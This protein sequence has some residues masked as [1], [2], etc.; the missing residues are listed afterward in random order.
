MKKLFVCMLAGALM[1]SAGACS[2]S[3]GKDSGTPASEP[4]YDSKELLDIGMWVGVSD[5]ITEYDDWGNKTG[6]VTTLTDEEFLE[7]YQ[8]IAESG[9]TIAFPG[10]EYMLWGTETYNKKCL[11][12]AHEVGIKQLI[13]IPAL[14]DYLSKAK[15]LVESGVDTEEQAVEK[16][17]NYLKPYVEYEYADAFYGC[18]IGDEPAADKFDQH[19]FAQKI[20]TQAA[21]DLCYYVNLFPVIA[22]GAQLGGATPISYET[23]IAQYLEKV[24]T[25]YLSYDHYPLKKSRDYFLE[26]SFLQNMEMVRKALDEEGKNR[27]MWTFLQ[28]ISFGNNRPL[29]SI[30]DAAFQAYSFL[31]YGGDGIQW[32]CFTCPPPYD[33]AGYFG[34][35]ALLDRDYQK[36]ATFDY[37]KTANGYLQAMM[38][39]Y[40]NFTWK[41]V[42]TSSEDGGEGNFERVQRMESAKT[43]KKVEGTEDVLVGVFEDKDAREGY[44]VVNFTDPGRKLDNEVTLTVESVH[45]AIV[46]LNG[47]KSVRPVKDGK[48]TLSLKSGEG[49]FVIP[50]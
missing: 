7:K 20:F 35:D 40:K 8:W 33:G 10:Y 14:N 9:I 27:K 1:F 30:G 21:P 28:S 2:G 12:A 48:L 22:G 6:K 39:Y 49:C 34:N 32:F 15:T 13:S 26:G 37:V 36:T 29:E 42:M 31:A 46:V 25:P 5:K 23:Y 11:K 17:K 50:Y 38:P 24:K 16:V 19:G 18:F 45:N 3:G 47:V 4:V 43:V 41:G 44:M